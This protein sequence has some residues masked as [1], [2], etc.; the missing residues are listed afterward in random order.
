VDSVKALELF[1]VGSAAGILG[2]LV[3]LGGGFVVIPVL[4]LFYNVAP[5]LT[6]GASLVMVLANSVS[7]SIAY[8]RQGRADVKLALLVAATGVPACIAGALAVRHVT[9]A[10]FDAI[11]AVLLLLFFV[12][13]MRRRNATKPPALHLPGLRPRTLVDAGG[14]VFRYAWSPA[15]VLLAGLAIG[16]IS[17]FFGIGGGIVFLIVFIAVF[18]MPAHVVTATSILSMLFVAPVGVATHWFEGNIDPTFAVPL[19]LGGL[20]GG[21]FGPQIARR[22]SSP[23]LLTV[24]AFAVLATALS[25][26][27][28]D[29]LSR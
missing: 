29:V 2:S 8:L 28:R 13:I 22:L 1:A 7:G 5:A 15:L 21:Q 6:A 18:A 17:S 26:V 3:G 19:A 11:Y 25:L 9:V 20:V 10:G 27:G 14:E 24:L 16:F 23:Q 4:R 12:D